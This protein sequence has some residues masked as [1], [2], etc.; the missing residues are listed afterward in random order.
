M[1]MLAKKIALFWGVM[2]MCACWA[3][4]PAPTPA[5]P[6]AVLE[7]SQGQPIFEKEA[8]PAPGVPVVA[9]VAVEPAKPEPLLQEQKVSPAP[10]SPKIGLL[11]YFKATHHGQCLHDA[12][13]LATTVQYEQEKRYLYLPAAGVCGIYA[14]KFGASGLFNFFARRGGVFSRLCAA[15][16]LGYSG[17][18]LAIKATDFQAGKRVGKG[19][20]PVCLKQLLLDNP[21]LIDTWCQAALPGD[22]VLDGMCAVAGLT[23]EPS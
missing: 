19:L 4:V 11:P 18:R 8:A 10:R 1:V 13:L 16:A 21:V 5:Q 23:V 15:T 9:P 3:M 20:C 2:D 12:D 22:A 6:P 14:V 7:S 17:W